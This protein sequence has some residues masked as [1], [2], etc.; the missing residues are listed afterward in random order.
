MSAGS[1]SLDYVYNASTT[2]L[3]SQMSREVWRVIHDTSPMLV[4]TIHGRHNDVRLHKD[5]LLK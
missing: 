3:A 1:C 5:T 2:I 4:R